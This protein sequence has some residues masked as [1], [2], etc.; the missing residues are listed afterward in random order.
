[1]SNEKVNKN[2]DEL[3]MREIMGLVYQLT[4][5]RE[6]AKAVLT[7][8]AQPYISAAL[9]S[10]HK[11]IAAYASII[12][13][14]MG[15]EQLRVQNF[16]NTFAGQIA[17]GVYGVSNGFDSQPMS[18][19]NTLERTNG[20]HRHH[21]MG[22]QNDGMEPEL[23]NELYNYPPSLG[24]L[25]QDHIEG[26]ANNGMRNKRRNLHASEASNEGDHKKQKLERTSKLVDRP[27]FPPF[28]PEERFIGEHCNVHL[29]P[30]FTVKGISYNCAVGRLCVIRQNDAVGSKN[31]NTQN[32]LTIVEFYNAMKPPL[33]FLEKSIPVNDT[34]EVLI[35]MGNWAVLGGSGG[36]TT[37]LS[38][39]T[40]KFGRVQVCVS[41]ILVMVRTGE[42]QFVIGNSSSELLVL[43]SRDTVDAE[44]SISK[45]PT[46][47]TVQSIKLSSDEHISAI[48]CSKTMKPQ[49]MA[50]GKVNGLTLFWHEKT[51]WSKYKEIDIPHTKENANVVW[52]L[53]FVDTFLFTGDARGQICIYNA[54]NGTLL[55]TLKTHQAPILAMAT[56][57]REVFAAG[58]DYRIQIIKSIS[59][60]NIRFDWQQTGQRLFHSNDVRAICVLDKQ[61]LI[62]GGSEHELFISD[63][64]THANPQIRSECAFFVTNSIYYVIVCLHL[65]HLD[66]WCKSIDGSFGQSTGLKRLLRIASGRLGFIKHFCTSPDGNFLA[67]AGAVGGAVRVFKLNWDQIHALLSENNAC[68]EEAAVKLIT[69]FWSSDQ[70][71]EQSARKEMNTGGKA[72]SAVYCTNRFLYFAHGEFNL[73]RLDLQTKRVQRF[74]SKVNGSHITK[75]CVDSDDKRLVALTVAGTLFVDL[76]KLTDPSDQMAAA[77]P[78]R[79]LLLTADLEQHAILYDLA[80]NLKLTAF[81]NSTLNLA[82]NEWVAYLNVNSAGAIVSMS[83]KARLRLMAINETKLNL[84]T[85]ESSE[86]KETKEIAKRFDALLSMALHSVLSPERRIELNTFD[87]DAWSLLLR[88]SQARPIDQVRSFYEKLVTQFNNAGRYWK[89]YIEHELRAKNFDNVETIFER[90]L[91]RVLN[92]DLWKCY[93]FYVKETKGHL[94][95]FREQ[96]AQTYDFALE[97]VGLDFQSY[98]IYL[99]YVTFL[100]SVNAV[101]QYAENQKI[102]AIR[103]I[104]RRGLSTPMANIEQ[105]WNDY[106]TFEKGINSTLAEK[107][108]AEANKDYQIARKMAK[109]YEQVTRGINRQAVSIPPRGTSAEMKQAELWRKFIQW[110]KSNPMGTE[111]YGQLAKRVIYAY[112]QSLLCIG[113]MPD[114][115]YEAAFFQQQAAQKLAEKGDVKLSTV[116]L[117][118]VIKLYER[119]ISGLMKDNQMLHF[120]YADFE[121]EKRRFENAKK[122]YDRLLACESV[123]P[124]LAYIQLMK[125]VRRTEGVKHS[126]LVFKRA[127]EDKRSN[128]HVFVAAA[129]LEYYCSKRP[130]VAKRI[131][132]LGLKKHGSDPQYALAYVEFLSHLNED[133]NTRVV[134]ERLLN[135]ENALDPEKSSETWDKYLEFESQVGDLTSVL[136]VDQRRRNVNPEGE[137]R[138]ALWLIDRYKFLHLTPCTA[139]QLKLM[140]YSSKISRQMAAVPH[141]NGFAG[142]SSTSVPPNALQ[143]GRMGGAPQQSSSTPAVGFNIELGGYARPDT[144]QMLPFKPKLPPA[145]YHPVPGG[146]FPPPPIVS[147][148]LQLLPPPRSFSGPFVDVEELMK[149]LASFNREP[150][151]TNAK[152]TLDP[153]AGFDGYRASDVKKE[154]YQLLN[155]TTDPLVLMASQEQH[156]FG[157]PKKRT[158]AGGDSD[159]EDEDSNQQLSLGGDVY[160]RRMNIKTK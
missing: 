49:M 144:S 9:S 124:T 85:D 91:V 145:S 28:R 67:L 140:G 98:S 61:W 139:D 100:K 152:E 159:S 17:P 55:K 141:Q 37:S 3:M 12:L 76:A 93:V 66:L 157:L 77:K 31:G 108:I 34:F 72:V 29:R 41:D 23:Y 158:I 36:R 15:V 65:S 68:H 64:F 126:R 40:S 81:A 80:S 48:G 155:T 24:E 113:Y 45:V 26:S 22:W 14:D 20:A 135:S 125:F 79:V 132:D 60:K 32:P 30:A 25:R 19:E 44:E 130:D 94:A 7:Y 8:E 105:L 153:S 106:C 114:I 117:S 5:S 122:I 42:K 18:A 39:F 120:A 21:Q 138:Q 90:C 58:V 51:Q 109:Q 110:E 97:K 129:F 11:S 50:V 75:I 118:D 116:M 33:I 38:P 96:L 149:S 102:T 6:G 78:C 53:I 52:S 87:V 160:K 43:N 47:S 73:I 56:D 146:V 46:F 137:D 62:S 128:F 107:M 4:K 151:K 150:P 142:S 86:S 123:D 104:Y 99:D 84:L 111:E 115:W 69:L 127:R 63:K 1:M 27:E 156:S 2:E 35:W 88:E 112:E 154:F 70:L 71:R 95:S 121:E 147:Q 82:S 143:N 16:N 134:F 13:K 57:G 133:N 103:K 131:F 101:G 92:I 119:A 136:K 59:H 89:A 83:N 54:Q 148:L 74:A 10:Q